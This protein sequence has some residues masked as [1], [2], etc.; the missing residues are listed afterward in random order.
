MIDGAPQTKISRGKRQQGDRKLHSADLLAPPP[1]KRTTTYGHQSAKLKMVRDDRRH[2]L[3]KPR[4]S[5]TAYHRCRT[6]FPSVAEASPESPT[7][8]PSSGLSAPSFLASSTASVAVAAAAA[9]NAAPVVDAET[10]SFLLKG[11]VFL[12]LGNL[13]SRGKTADSDRLVF[14]LD[15]FNKRDTK[16]SSP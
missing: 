7:F 5:F 2:P 9:S 13:E 14:I 4:S 12:M 11:L 16:L 15:V 1:K 3:I 8:C 10:A 6:L